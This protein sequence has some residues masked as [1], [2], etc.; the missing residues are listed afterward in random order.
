MPNLVYNWT[1]LFISKGEALNTSVVVVGK[2]GK[3]AKRN[4]IR[5]QLR[6]SAYSYAYLGDKYLEVVLAKSGLVISD[7][8]YSQQG[9]MLVIDPRSV[10]A[11]KNHISYSEND[12]VLAV[13]RLIAQAEYSLRYF[14]PFIDEILDEIIADEMDTRASDVEN[15]QTSS[16]Y[17]QLELYGWTPE[18]LTFKLS[19]N[20]V[21]EERLG[22]FEGDYGGSL[23]FEK[24][25]GAGEYTFTLP[26]PEIHTDTYLK[27]I[28]E[29]LAHEISEALTL[30]VDYVEDA[31]DEQ[32]KADYPQFAKLSKQ[33][34]KRSIEL[35]EEFDLYNPEADRDW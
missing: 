1:R 23:K 15:N 5:V 24:L 34:R 8:T 21:V 16:L 31:L 20:D 2:F 9:V 26:R 10:S 19:L 30:H 7:V 4:Q 27:M 35:E 28:A 33:D 6:P 13:S 29:L 22:S 25:V 3:S 12:F 32:E 14:Y 11:L 17:F 18:N